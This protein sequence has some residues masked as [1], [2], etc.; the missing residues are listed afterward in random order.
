METHLKPGTAAPRR[1]RSNGK[2]TAGFL[3][4]S[5]TPNHQPRFWPVVWML[6]ALGLAGFACNFPGGGLIAEPTPEPTQ[7][8]PVYL[9]TRPTATPLPTPDP[10]EP[11]PLPQIITPPPMTNTAPPLLYYTQAGDTLPTV[12]VRFGVL[13]EEITSPDIVPEEALLN[14][15][16]LLVI[17]D[18]LGE[19]SPNQQLLPDSEMVF[20]P[21]A[22]D[23]D[24]T[25]FVSTAGGRLSGYQEF[26]G[27]SGNVSGAEIIRRVALD[28]SINPM[29][30]LALLEHQGG[31]VFGEP[32]NLAQD[33]YPFGLVDINRQGL[34][35]QLVWVV[36]QLSVGYYG[37]REGRLTEL[38]FTD[39][40]ALRIAPD[41]NAGTVALQYLFSKLYSQERWASVLNPENGLPATYT[42]MF[43][44]PWQR[45]LMVEPL[46]P[47]DLA[48]PDL[49]LPFL[50]NQLWAYTGGPHGAW[51]HDG[52]WAAIDF[53][54]GSAEPGCTVSYSWATAAASGLVTRSERG[55]VVID[56]DGD[57]YEQTGWAL[58]YLHIADEGRIPVGT[59][60]EQGDKIGF[61][62]CEGG[63]ATGTHIHLARKY[64]GE[65]IPADGP[66]PFVLGGWRV[67]AG[68]QAYK[69][70]L[71][72]GE[73]TVIASDLGIYSAR[74]IRT[75]Q[76]P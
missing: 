14:P 60:V 31:W 70:T 7:I 5:Q 18:R 1:T 24:V 11:T 49:I 15:G 34:Y 33:Q 2:K 23:F 57:G 32:G 37:W 22:M 36:N 59:L 74:I 64:N 16:Q 68:N 9:F 19:T 50:R 47:P 39:G 25:G 10:L 17:P 42:Q 66:L 20:A 53:A 38:Q 62:S 72:R 4:H 12:A 71:T 69:G 61:P 76:D 44:N 58:L 43:G 56:M 8:E 51:E 26:L 28:N 45:A 6:L 21:S 46:Y 73:E 55:V 63:I 54:P 3:G 13:P 75:D 41:L 27:K 65:W 35:K 67:H 48:Q 30:L 52:A 29:L 40:S